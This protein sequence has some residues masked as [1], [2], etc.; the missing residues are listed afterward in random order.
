[1]RPLQ[2]LILV[3]A[4]WGLMVSGMYAGELAQCFDVVRLALMSGAALNKLQD[5]QRC[6]PR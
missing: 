2:E 4:A 5:V 3:N 6:L 1:L